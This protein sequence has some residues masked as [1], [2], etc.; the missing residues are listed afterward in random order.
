MNS[1]ETLKK[2][3]IV[4]GMVSDKKIEAILPSGLRFVSANTTD[5]ATYDQS[6]G[7]WSVPTLQP[8]EVQMLEIFFKNANLFLTNQLS[9]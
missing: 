5:T 1:K 3:H 6:T 8:G 7:I 4:L 2:V 9:C